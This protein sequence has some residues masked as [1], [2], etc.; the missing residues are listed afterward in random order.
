MSDT[1]SWS[2]LVVLIHVLDAVVVLY[3]LL[4]AGVLKC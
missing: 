2:R 1:E 3:G 4:G